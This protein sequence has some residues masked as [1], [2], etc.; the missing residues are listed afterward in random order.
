MTLGDRLRELRA[1]KGLTQ[2]GLAKETGLSLHAI[3]SYESGRRRP[4]FEATATL[5]KY[6][7]V[8]GEYL[9]GDLD[10][11]AYLTQSA[12]VQDELERLILCFKRFSNAFRIG[13]LVE[14]RLAATALEEVLS[15]FSAYVLRP[16]MPVELTVDEIM[17]PLRAVFDLNAEGRAE[18]VKR[19]TELTEL[20][21]YKL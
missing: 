18:L 15:I 19:A 4:S 11:D 16:G 9:R 12:D 8:S 20:D 6:F 3:N 13:D 14:Q 1:E 10:R 17:T 7:G 2:A 5:E 21:R